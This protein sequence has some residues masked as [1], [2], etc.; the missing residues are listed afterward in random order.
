M[1]RFNFIIG[2][3]DISDADLDILKLKFSNVFIFKKVDMKNIVSS[4]IDVDVFVSGKKLKK[5]TA[6]FLNIIKIKTFYYDKY[7]YNINEL[8]S[9]INQK[10]RI[11]KDKEYEFNSVLKILD[12]TFKKGNLNYSELLHSIRVGIN[13]YNFGKYL[14][15][16]KDN[17][18]DLFIAALLHD[19][20]KVIIPNAV[21][22]KKGHLDEKEYETMKSHP[23]ISSN[24]VPDKIKNI[25]KEHHERFD[26][27]G[28][29][30]NLKGND[31][32]PEARIIGI[33]DSYD[34]MTT[35]RCYKK[36]IDS[37]EALN[38]LYLCSIDKVF[39]GK[40][41]MYDPFYTKKYLELYGF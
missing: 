24:I 33:V 25:V 35:R 15:Y 5:T 7:K 6:S 28:Y 20:G 9:L 40:G 1:T 27:S 14:G 4:F 34:A 13:A 31:I 10:I 26:G 3:S 32:L 36:K 11:L 21:L 29:P 38:E 17:L 2:Y 30:Y 22:K 19:V 23:I 18:N 39:G 16:I 8:V 41:I 37:N 12:E